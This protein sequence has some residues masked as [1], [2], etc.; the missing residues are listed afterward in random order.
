MKT[1]TLSDLSAS[2]IK[3]IAQICEKG[4]AAYEW[5]DTAQ[6][7]LTDAEKIQI[8]NITVRLL[9]YKTSLMNEATIWA[10]AI[11]PLLALAERDNIQAW[12]EVSLRAQYP[13]VELQGIADGVLGDSITGTLETPYL[14]VVEAKRGLESQ[15]P[16][17]QLYGHLL[18]AARLNW[19]DDQKSV[20]EVF[21]C[22]TI[23]DS[24]TLMRA[25]VQNVDS[26]RPQMTLESSREY[27]EKI[28]AE[29]ILKILKQIVDR[30]LRAYNATPAVVGVC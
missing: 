3:T 9:N 15:D 12:A 1:L 28:E 6:T 25:I 5:I 8:A 13:H 4:I 19:E 24:W 17:F 29:T 18:V 7:A 27:V 26:D 30:R 14:M 2:D 23:S 21:G 10:R 20:Q 22:Y 11:Y 16:R